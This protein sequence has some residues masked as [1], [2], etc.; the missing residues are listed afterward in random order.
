MPRPSVLIALCVPP[1]PSLVQPDTK[2]FN[3]LLVAYSHAA[4]PEGARATLAKMQE[5]SF[6]PDACSYNTARSAC[7]HAAPPS[8]KLALELMPEMVAVGI[9]PD[10]I[11]YS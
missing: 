4:D 10:R 9:R 5:A 2:L 1:T 8:P 6:A 11:T 7:A 3:A